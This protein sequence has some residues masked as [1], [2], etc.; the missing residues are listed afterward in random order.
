MKESI[1]HSY[2]IVFVVLYS[3]LW[4]ALLKQTPFKRKAYKRTR[5]IGVK[6][7]W[8]WQPDESFQNLKLDA[9]SILEIIFLSVLH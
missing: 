1:F 8:I 6:D 3:I 4:Y 2:V 7:N 9:G 5:G